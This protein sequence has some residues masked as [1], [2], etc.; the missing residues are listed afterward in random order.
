MLR[1]A[2]PAMGPDERAP[3]AFYERGL[4]AIR[5]L[6]DRHGEARTLRDL[7]IAMRDFD[8]SLR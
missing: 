5:E 7:K 2:R 6:G 8:G 1:R 4:E 3:L